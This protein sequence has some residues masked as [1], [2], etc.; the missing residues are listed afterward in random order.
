LLLPFMLV[1]DCVICRGI[2]EVVVVWIEGEELVKV[3]VETRF[4]PI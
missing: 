2:I 4:I 1:S 3:D